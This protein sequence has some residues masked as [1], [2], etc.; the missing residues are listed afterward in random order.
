MSSVSYLLKRISNMSFKSMFERVDIVKAKTKKSKFMIFNDMVWCGLRYGAGYVDY[1]VIGFYKLNS[2]QRKTMLTRGIN[3]KFVKELNEKEYWHI[4]DKKNEFNSTFSKFIK[5]EW[6]YPL[7]ENKDEFMKW[8]DKHQVVFA[9][10][11]AGQCG[12]GIEKIN[13]DEWKDRKE[14]LYNYLVQNKLELLEEP[15]KQHEEMNKLNSSSV[16]TVRVVT[17]MNKSDDVTILTAFSRIGNGNHV[18]NFNSGG[19][20]AKV[21]INTGK[22]VEEAVNKK[23]EIFDKHPIT[24]TSIKEFQIPNWNEAKEMVMEAAKLSP[25]VRYIGWDVAIGECGPILVEGNQFPGHDIYQVA[26]KMKEGQL[27]VLP[28][29]EKAL[30]EKK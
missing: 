14:E 9:K 29:F 16:N 12:K 11:N 8:F 20:T 23:G 21:D 25:H 1:D 27:G 2:K 19:M 6:L 5:R 15:I 17:V 22:I 24:G 3:N 28:E 13:L 30:C 4:F 7:S 18:D 10:P 26:E